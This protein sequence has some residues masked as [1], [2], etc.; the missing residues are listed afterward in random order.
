MLDIAVYAATTEI[1]EGLLT[2]L[3]GQNLLPSAPPE[4]YHYTTLETIQKILESDDIRLMHAEY[5]NDQ[6]ELQEARSL[7]KGRLETYASPAFR[8]AVEAAYD[9]QAIGLDVYIFCMSTGILGNPMPQDMLS[10]WRAYGQDGRGGCLSLAPNGLAALVHHF[11]VGFRRNPVIYDRATQTALIDGILTQGNA[12]HGAGIANAID[13]TVAALIF[14]TPLIKHPGFKEEQEWRLIYTP[15]QDGPQPWLGFHPRRDF[16]APFVTLQDLWSRL[17]PQLQEIPGL[18][19]V[20]PPLNVPEPDA[21]RLLPVQSI[22]VGP[23]GHQE[24]NERAMQKVIAQGR[25]GLGLEK[26]TIP[27]RS[28]N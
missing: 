16:L 20:A 1:L 26:S 21:T 15:L 19:I 9:A 4:L 7:I 24:L 8:S 6:R 27:Y 3:A 17:R 11:P 13:A 2:T 14:A 25:P 22:M 5:S 18:P 12:R 23:S 28:L 10:Q